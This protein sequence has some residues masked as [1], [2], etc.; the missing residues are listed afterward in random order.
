MSTKEGMEYEELQQPKHKISKQKISKERK[1]GKDTSNKTNSNEVIRV[2]APSRLE[3]AKT[4]LIAMLITGLVAF[5]A[6]V[7][8]A[9]RQHES[10]QAK[11]DGAVQSAQATPIKK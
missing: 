6:G 9:N 8:Y 5:I 11:V 4:V 2:Y 3:V 1:M 7:S 10:I